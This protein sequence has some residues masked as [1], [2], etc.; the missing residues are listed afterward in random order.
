M[1][2]E[3]T[4]PVTPASATMNVSIFG[5]TLSTIA[6]TIAASRPV[7]SATATPSITAR[8]TPSGGKAMKFST[9]S[10]TMRE[11]FSPVSS[12]ST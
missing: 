3:A 7:C 8:I 11:M 12:D 6:R 9:A 2:S 10:V 1:A 4:E 5:L